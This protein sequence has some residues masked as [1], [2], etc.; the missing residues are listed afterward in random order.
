MSVDIKNLHIPPNQFF[1]WMVEDMSSTDENSEF[2]LSLINKLIQLGPLHVVIAAETSLAQVVAVYLKEIEFTSLIVSDGNSLI[3][4][5]R[6]EIPSL[7]I[8]EAG[9]PELSG[10]DAIRQ[11][12][13]DSLHP[14]SRVPVIMMGVQQVHAAC[15]ASGADVCLRP[16]IRPIDLFVALNRLLV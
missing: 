15:L 8:V 11:I 7:L 1:L 12:Q 6:D 5:C 14:A 16:P 4:Q 13:A 2:E 9:L 10:M 3:R